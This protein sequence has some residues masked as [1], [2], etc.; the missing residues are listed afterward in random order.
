MQ[1]Y[2]NFGNDGFNPWYFEII[3]QIS[4]NSEGY[5]GRECFKTWDTDGRMIVTREPYIMFQVMSGKK[6]LNLTIKQWSQGINDGVFCLGEFQEEFTWLP[7][8]VWDSVRGQMKIQYKP[9]EFRWN[10]DLLRKKYGC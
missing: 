4:W 9:W 6:L 2:K 3:K 10:I 7:E 8:W 1:C 5:S